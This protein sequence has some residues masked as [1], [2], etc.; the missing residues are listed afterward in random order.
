MRSIYDTLFPTSTYTL[1]KLKTLYDVQLEWITFHNSHYRPNDWAK[2]FLTIL[3]DEEKIY[4]ICLHDR[5]IST[6]IG[7][8]LFRSIGK[9]SKCNFLKKC[10]VFAF[11][12]FPSLPPLSIAHSQYFFLLLCGCCQSH[13]LG[14]EKQSDNFPT[15]SCVEIKLANS[16]N[17]SAHCSFF[18]A[19]Y[20][21][22]H[23]REH[24]C[25]LVLARRELFT[26]EFCFEKSLQ[27][28][29]GLK[30]KNIALKKL[31]AFKICRSSSY[32][33]AFFM[34]PRRTNRI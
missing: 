9:K 25:Y 20:N 2:F 27:K 3:N 10:C 13:A 14:L 19:S 18:Q 6:N 29:F 15:W 32:F 30:T 17:F 22:K 16:V 7:W 24:L 33:N 4:F 28:Y 5:N 11:I 1:D 34:V 31:I 21:I 26:M 8:F 23:R 12:H